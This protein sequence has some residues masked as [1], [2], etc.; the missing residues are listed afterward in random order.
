[1]TDEYGMTKF[2]RSFFK[3]AFAAVLAIALIAGV[4]T[5]YFNNRWKYELDLTY[6]DS[7]AYRNNPYKVEYHEYEIKN[8]TKRKLKN[9]TAV[10]VA[11]DNIFND[12]VKL[13]YI[14]GTLQEGETD[15]IKIYETWLENSIKEKKPH[16]WYSGFHIKKI[17]YK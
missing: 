3:K 12:K 15:T 6:V 9:V 13:E 10:I 8:K 5:A 14:I 16:F 11:E 4:Y 7:V 1:M 2:D 17:T